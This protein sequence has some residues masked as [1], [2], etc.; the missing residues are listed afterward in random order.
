MLV[1]RRRIGETV[2]IGAD[3]QVQVLGV[4]GD[5]IKLGFI[6]PKEIQILR[7]EL[8]QGIVAENMAA[9]EQISQL[10]QEEILNLLKKFK[11]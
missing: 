3:I 2:M 10:Q 1:L 7:N 11:M 9:K 5:Q 8:Y 4:E 6:A